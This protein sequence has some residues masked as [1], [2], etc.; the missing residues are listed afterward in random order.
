MSKPILI[1]ISPNSGFEEAVLALKTLLSPWRWQKGSTLEKLKRK[2]N[3]YFS[4][5]NTYLLN[6]GRSGLLLVLK[7]LQLKKNDEVLVQAF[8]CVAVPNAIIASGGRPVFVDTVQNGFNLDVENLKMKISKRTRALI[9]Q[10]TFGTADDLE[11]ISN[12]CQQ[13]GILLIEDCAHALGAKYHGRPVGSFGDVAVLSFGR[14][15]VISSIFGG[16][17]LT[18]H[19]EIIKKLTLY[20]RQLHFPTKK[21]IAKQLFH[22][23][24]FSLA[25]PLY[26]F[27]HY[28]FSL[29]KLLVAG[30]RKLS[31][32]SLPVSQKDK[33]GQSDL[34]VNK[35][36]EALAKQANLQ[37]GKLEK[38]NKN[39]Q[40]IA[41]FYQKNLRHLTAKYPIQLPKNNEG[42]IYLRYSILTKNPEQMISFL[43]RKGVGLGNWYRPV[44]SPLG[45]NLQTINYKTGSCPHAEAVSHTVV[46]L[47]T[48]PKMSLADAQRVVGAIKDY[49]H[50]QNN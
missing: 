28:K 21:F 8:T 9:V 38:F 15:K 14:D 34:P 23:I 41:H 10:H 17:V 16:A 43:A 18:N 47:P 12:F 40:K 31:L 24:L 48:H 49:V 30:A 39:R 20:E 35:L 5:T 36:P 32:I 7:A 13:K 22:P 2:I 29:G 27:P 45:V 42:S 33:Q 50:H 1:S 11:T 26:F 19:Q 6:S 46:N 4:T 37:W 3:N 44:I 25:I